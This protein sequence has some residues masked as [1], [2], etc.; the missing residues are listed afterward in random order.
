MIL[1]LICLSSILHAGNEIT[2]ASP[3]PKVLKIE[4]ELGFQEYFYRKF[5]KKP[6]IKW[7]E[8][9]GTTDILRYALQFK[10]KSGIDIM[11][12]GGIDP[13]E[14]LK[15][16]DLLIPLEEFDDIL[17]QIPQTL[18]GMPLRDPDKTWVA[19]NLSAFGLAYRADKLL[20]FSEITWSTLTLDELKGRVSLS[21]PRKSGSARFI[22]E[23]ILQKY[24][25][26]A[27]WQNF[28]RMSRNAKTFGFHSSE[29][30]KKLSLGE[31]LI[32]PLVESHGFRA[33]MLNP[34][35][36]FVIPKD[37]PV[38]FGDSIA[39]LK[40]CADEE[41]ARE[42]IRF[43][44]TDFQYILSSKLGA[45][46]GPRLTELK[47]FPV[48]P[49]AYTSPHV[50]VAENPFS[51]VIPVNFKFDHKLGTKRWYELS[52]LFG[53]IIVDLNHIFKTLSLEQVRRLPSPLSEQEFM[54]IV[55]TGRWRDV[56]NRD[57]DIS[58]IRA[59]FFQMIK[60]SA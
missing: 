4:F 56:A 20:N 5:R 14:E 2:I 53:A 54:D 50:I 48:L 11:F 16:L 55:N 39:I 42:L 12:G 3:H 19:T 15:S 17:N 57:T 59:R 31:I 47:R 33:T 60:N 41:L 7:L 1:L 32:A 21:D 25:W 34:N 45:E 35:I 38:Y 26:D 9:G 40:G 52:V 13:F 36:K 28:Y 24:G 49:K 6:K 18:F 37:L 46:P 10:E 23:I 58:M 44:L 29:L 30:I 27:A 43:S 51:S 22:Y 8:L